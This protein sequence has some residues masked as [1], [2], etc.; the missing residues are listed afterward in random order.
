MK[1]VMEN[2]INTAYFIRL[3]GPNH[4]QFQAFLAEVGSD[5]NDVIYFSQV[6]WLS[7]AYTLA[8]YWSLL[9]EIKTLMR[10]KGRCK[11]PG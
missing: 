7:R 8:R 3:K 10:I 11:V 5:S 9:E 6:R 2:V 4:R 1:H